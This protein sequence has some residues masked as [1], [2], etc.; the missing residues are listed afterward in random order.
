M[1]LDYL[2][3]FVLISTFS[4]IFFILILFFTTK[5]TNLGYFL[6]VVT[7]IYVIFPI[8]KGFTNSKFYNIL[9]L[10][11]INT[12]FSIGW[13]CVEIGYIKGNYGYGSADEF[14]SILSIF[15][16][17]IFIIYGKIEKKMFLLC[18]IPPVL[19]LSFGVFLTGVEY[20]NL[21]NFIF[22]LFIIRVLYY[23]IYETNVSYFW[24]CL[25]FVISI[26]CYYVDEYRYYFHSI[27]HVTNMVSV[28]FIFKS[29]EIEF[30]NELKRINYE[31]LK[32]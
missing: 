9:L 23:I 30:E 25:F 4:Y 2:D 26:V 29:K 24:V 6:T 22:L 5:E 27:W 14:F 7:H 11:I 8:I 19:R 20:L 15:C 3:I 12:F 18:L 31:E 17:C 32:S 1:E 21:I 16:Y 10:T 13:H 28:Y